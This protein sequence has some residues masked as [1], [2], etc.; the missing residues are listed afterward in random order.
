MRAAADLDPVGQ[1]VSVGVAVVEEA[2]LF[3]DQAAR[4]RAD[5]AG[6]PADRAAAG[7]ALDRLDRPLDVRPLLGFGDVLVVDP[8]PAVAGDLEAGSTIARPRRD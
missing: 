5:P 7:R 4:V 3:D 8:A 2:A 6:V 1:V